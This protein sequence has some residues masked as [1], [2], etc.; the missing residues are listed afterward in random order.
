M[1]TFIMMGKYSKEALQGISS[2]RTK[3]ADQLITNCGGKLNSIYVVLG[4]YDL[5]L[6][7]EFPDMPSAVKASIGLHK[8]TG[9]SFSTAEAITA[10]EFD[11]LMSD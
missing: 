7:C 2:D 8:L 4:D 6:V 9:I 3:E 11:S 1:A 10:D 5:H